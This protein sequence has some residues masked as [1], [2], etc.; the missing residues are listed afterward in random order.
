LSLDRPAASVKGRKIA[1]LAGDGVDAEQL[2]AVKKALLA[3]GC[4]VEL[5]AAHA[6]VITDSKGK[7]QKVN[8]AAPNAPSVVYDGAIILGGD[9]A[10]SL[11]KSGLAIH[12]LNEAFRHGKPLAF[13]TEGNLVMKA[14]RLPKADGVISADGDAAI[15]AFIK[16]LHQHRFPRRAVDGIPA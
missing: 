4:V 11:G 12:F 6:G 9:G 14:A 15:A 3:E 13:L 1:L 16:A 5:V 8:R 2:A 10:A 7:P